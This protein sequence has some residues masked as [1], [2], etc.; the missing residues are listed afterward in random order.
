VDALGEL[1]QQADRVG[2]RGLMLL[3]DQVERG[4]VVRVRGQ[5][6]EGLPAR[7]DRR[8]LRGV[9]GGR[10]ASAP[11]ATS[12]PRSLRHPRG[13]RT[14][15]VQSRSSEQT[16]CRDDPLLS[17]TRILRLLGSIVACRGVGRP[18]IHR[19]GG[20]RIPAAPQGGGGG[21]RVAMPAAG[22]SVSS[23]GP[24]AWRTGVWVLVRYG[25]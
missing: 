6:L 21:R 24:R 9:R 18:P 14:W 5:Q 7:P 12:V 2:A 16:S 15:Y 19:N 20:A 23:V 11:A 1:P 13:A 8:D 3:E 25:V 10:G 17:T 4:R 22:A